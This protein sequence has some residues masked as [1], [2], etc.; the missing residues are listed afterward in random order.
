MQEFLSKTHR[1]A[2]NQDGEI[3]VYP[4]GGF[5][6]NQT[7]IT[8]DGAKTEP[9]DLS[10]E[11]HLGHYARTAPLFK[12][13]YAGDLKWHVDISCGFQRWLGTQSNRA[14]ARAFSKCDFDSKVYK[15]ILQEARKHETEY[16]CRACI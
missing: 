2:L 11:D 5:K 16:M 15:K 4:L 6:V 12:A 7:T 8:K 9:L 10:K 3:Y 1:C 13:A 14:V